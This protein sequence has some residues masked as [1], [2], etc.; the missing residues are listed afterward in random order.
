MTMKK[1][2]MA[3]MVVLCAMS[4]MN[5]A[6][7]APVTTGTQTL[8]AKVT[9]DTCTINGI[10]AT[11]TFLV[12]ANDAKRYAGGHNLINAIDMSLSMT[13]CGNSVDAQVN[14]QG[15]DVTASGWSG[16]QL[17]AL[18]GLFSRTPLKVNDTQSEPDDWAPGKS[19]NYVLQN[20]AGKIPIFFQLMKDGGV[21]VKP[22]AGVFSNTAEV[23][24]DNK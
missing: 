15:S 11:K 19:M 14:M 22:Q 8:T 13:G 10:N 12:N 7:A 18:R 3:G 17:G 1:T 24:I 21:G 4:G 20:G 6:Q 9:A 2:L 16:L 23:I 5:A